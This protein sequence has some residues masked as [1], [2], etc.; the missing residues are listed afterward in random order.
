MTP[1]SAHR[2]IY[3]V[4]YPPSRI[5]PLPNRPTP[6]S[7]AR[8]TN[9]FTMTLETLSQSSRNQMTTGPPKKRARTSGGGGGGGGGLGSDSS[10]PPPSPP[11]AP[12]DELETVDADADADEAEPLLATPERT[13][14]VQ[15]YEGGREVDAETGTYTSS[16]YVDAF[17]LALDTVLADEAYLFSEDELEVF[18]KYRSLPYAAQHL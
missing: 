15:K 18:V 2:V 5:P 3:A 1:S 16:I 9:L 12:L 14:A 4:A 13:E 6:R 8:S 11:S 7:L 17:V 10:T